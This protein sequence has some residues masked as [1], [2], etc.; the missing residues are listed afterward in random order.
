MIP[1]AKPIIPMPLRQLSL[2]VV[3]R[4]WYSPIE[5]Q[6]GPLSPSGLFI[7][8]KTPFSVSE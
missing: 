8:T 1:P 5:M 7:H 2:R 4:S 6:I 3:S